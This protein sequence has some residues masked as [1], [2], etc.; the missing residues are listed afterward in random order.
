M[1]DEK[2]VQKNK[3]IEIVPTLV[4]DDFVLNVEDDTSSELKVQDLLSLFFEQNFYNYTEGFNEFSPISIFDQMAL[5]SQLIK[6]HRT[7]DFL[8][9]YPIIYISPDPS[10]GVS[11]FYT[12]LDPITYN[13]SFRKVRKFDFEMHE[14]NL[15][16]CSSYNS[17]IDYINK[18][19]FVP[20]YTLARFFSGIHSYIC[21]NLYYSGDSPSP[22]T[23]FINGFLNVLI[24]NPD[25]CDVFADDFFDYDQDWCYSIIGTVIFFSV[26]AI[27]MLYIIYFTLNCIR[28]SGVA[29]NRDDIRKLKEKNKM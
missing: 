22:F 17:L 3:Y 19:F 15:Q 29:F 27:V 9:N 25:K 24:L 10:I 13:V 12:I 20:K 6:E 23:A 28:V 4:S 2:V 5:L 8:R 1:K 21:E 14:F 7:Y 18:A 16:T 11:H 26:F